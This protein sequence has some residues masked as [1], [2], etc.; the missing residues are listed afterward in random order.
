M[1]N[2]A[3]AD[4]IQS[5]YPNVKY[6]RLVF[7]DTSNIVRTRVFP[8]GRFFDKIVFSGQGLTSAIFGFPCLYDAVFSGAPVGEFQV[9]P[10]LNTFRAL[11]HNPAHAIVFG[12]FFTNEVVPKPV[13]LDPRSFLRR[14]TQQLAT[15]FGLVLK[16]GFES[17]F[18]L[19]SESLPQAPA[20]EQKA[21][22]DQT[23]SVLR[24]LDSAIYSQVAAF[25]NTTTVAIL[26]AIVDTLEA[27]DIPVEQFHPESASGQFEIVTAYDNALSAV[28][29]LVQTRII[30]KEVTRKVGGNV[31]ATFAPKVYPQQAGTASH[32]HIS[33]WNLDS[34]KNLFSDDNESQRAQENLAKNPLLLGAVSP[35]GQHFLA[36]VLKHLP[37]LMAI[38]TPTPMSF[39][40]IQPCFWSGAYQVWGVQNREAPVRVSHDGKQFEF[41]TLDGTA[42][43][44]LALGAIIVAGMDG[45]RNKLDLPAACQNDPGVLSDAE[46]ESAGII[47][48][49]ASVDAALDKLKQSQ[50]LVD[51]LG[52]EL[53]DNFV[54]VRSKESA[55][56]DKM[57]A[58]TVKRIMIDRY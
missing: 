27:V 20:V 22:D 5:S 32:A 9:V 12:N 7:T 48:L 10:D 11:P 30:I 19:L 6:V 4:E 13:A 28:D 18:C 47:R 36:G 15:E 29:K 17:E 33:L 8:A 58:E 25:E 55:A 24:P 16:A 44:Y 56:I 43:P 52:K 26:D 14:V 41:K 1:S 46:R 53:V 35:V 34:S 23:R 39:H 21:V 3:T 42:N 45:L 31:L 37:A 49:P 57:N 40:R 2:N 50:A 51:G 54:T 38:T